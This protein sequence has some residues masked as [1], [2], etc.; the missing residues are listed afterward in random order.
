MRSGTAVLVAGL[1]VVV[2]ILAGCSEAGNSGNSDGDGGGGSGGGSPSPDLGPQFESLADI[3]SYS[4]AK[5]H[6]SA[7]VYNGYIYVTGGY[8]SPDFIS[9]VEYSSVSDDGSLGG[10]SA[11]TALPEGRDGHRSF[12]YNGYLYVVAG[13]LDSGLTNT[14]LSAKIDT[15][16]SLGAF[17]EVGTLNTARASFGL[18]VSGDTL[19]VMGGTIGGFGTKSV[20]YAEIEA[21]GNIGTF[22][23]VDSAYELN[24]SRSFCAATAYDGYLYIAG[25]RKSGSE[26]HDTLEF[27][28]IQPDKSPGVFSVATNTMDTPREF[29]GLTVYNYYL[30]AVGGKPTGGPTT[31]TIEYCEIDS[32]SGLPGQFSYTD[33]NL[34]VELYHDVAACYEDHLLVIGGYPS[35]DVYS[36]KFVE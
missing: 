18:A 33:N 13:T 26:S 32:S 31:D 8:A 35:T 7:C 19:Y 28:E 10:F 24:H 4:T 6:F 9:T 5:H 30:Y 23:E 14:V 15:D 12:G 34:P 36:A 20:E 25:G 3:G 29:F 11:T 16:G 2:L 27:S 22:T 17:T 1:L 21:N